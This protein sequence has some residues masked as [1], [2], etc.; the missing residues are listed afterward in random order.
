MGT[1]FYVYLY[2][3]YF[4]GLVS[5][6]GCSSLHRWITGSGML[7]AVIG[8]RLF[9]ADYWEWIIGSGVI[10]SGALGVK[11]WEWILGDEVLCLSVPEVFLE[12]SFPFRL[13]FA[14]SIQCIFVIPGISLLTIGDLW[15]WGP[16]IPLPCLSFTE[17]SFSLNQ[18]NQRPSGT[19]AKSAGGASVN[20]NEHTAS[21]GIL[22]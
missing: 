12:V 8:S 16:L 15:V 21:H 14:S 13:F 7:E 6:S 10:R 1:K 11:Y 9:G 4:W 18:L 19:T 20:W 5:L 22:D 2:L 3:K 17:G